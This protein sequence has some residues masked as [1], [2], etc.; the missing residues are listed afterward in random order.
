MTVDIIAIFLFAV[1]IFLG[2]R[3]GAVSQVGRVAAAVLA[4]VGAPYGAV[5]VRDIM[6]ADTELSRPVVEATS[7]FVAGILIYV[8]VALTGW[9]IVRA[10]HA[11]SE[12]LT[13]L[14][15][16]GGGTIGAIKG[17]L[18]I[19][20]VLTV[21]ALLQVPAEKL[22]PSNAMGLRGGHA[23]EFVIEH[24]I[25]APWQLP[26]LSELH[27]ALKVRYYADELDR[28]RV[29]HDHPRAAD[30]LRKD[31]I[32]MLTDDPALMQAVVDDYYPV[33]LADPRV[34]AALSDDKITQTLS[35]IDWESLLKEL[36]SPVHS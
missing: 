12:H 26:E 34:R 33:T 27:T 23:T 16:L 4:V 2:W 15:K 30:F 36:M 31:A 29:L 25:L 22:D 17:T 6:F 21:F 20:F 19:Y 8:A 13:L 5:M 7:L 9:L 24:N 32:A 18:L 14:D 1:A 35:S 3:A 10:M 11:T 28:E